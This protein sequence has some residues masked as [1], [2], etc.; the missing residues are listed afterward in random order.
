MVVYL[1]VIFCCLVCVYS[2]DVKKRKIGC[3]IT[4]WGI[5]FLLIVVA[6]MRYQIGADTINYMDEFRYVKKLSDLSAQDFSD[7]RFMPGWIIFASMCKSLCPQF[8]GLQFIHATIL[9]ISI[10]LFIRQFSQ[11]RFTA[12]LMYVLLAYLNLNTEILRESLAM[13]IFFLAIVAF[14]RNKWIVY[15]ILCFIV[16]MIHVSGVITFIFP[17]GKLLSSHSRKKII[18]SFICIIALSGV[19]WNFFQTYIIDFFIIGAIEVGAEAYINN[20]YV[21]NINGIIVSLTTRCVI[22]FLTIFFALKLKHKSSNLIHLGYIYIIIGVFTLFNSVI[23]LHFQTYATIPFIIILSDTLFTLT[24]KRNVVVASIIL[25]GLIIPQYYTYCKP[26]TNIYN[27][28][29]KT[30]VYQRYVP[31]QMWPERNNTSAY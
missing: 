17:V 24:R 8:I 21:Q 26:E 29:L 15:F 14:V 13:S 28:N 11:Y 12:V 16:S 2:F 25:F 4:F 27:D 20:D 31:Y 5:C 6:G 30:Y 9:N 23:F 10:F 22:P 3:D 18:T 7:T 1:F 19:L